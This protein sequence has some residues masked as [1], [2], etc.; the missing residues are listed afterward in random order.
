GAIRCYNEQTGD[1]LF[2]IP[3]AHRGS[4]RCVCLTPLY[5]ISGGRDG[6]VRVWSDGDSH[7][8]VGNFDEH[9]APVTG[10]RVDR[11]RPKIVYSCSED[12]TLVTLDLAQSRRIHCHV[13]KEG[14]FSGLEQLPVGDME[15]ITCDNAGSVKWWD[16]DVSDKPLS[17]LVTWSPQRVHDGQDNSAERK[18]TSMALSP[19]SNTGNGEFLLL[20]TV[21]G[22]VQARH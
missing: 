18:L 17:M 9:R 20:G 8:L 11:E 22:D 4:V 6:T 5:L 16:S 7:S 21:T 14:P 19:P 10:L 13:V 1:S 2:E 3:G 15:L 12:K